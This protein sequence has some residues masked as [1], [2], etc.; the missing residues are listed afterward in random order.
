MRTFISANWPIFAIVALLA[1][2]QPVAQ[3][4]GYV[5]VETEL[6]QIETGVSDKAAVRRAIGMPATRNEHYGDAWFYV[7]SRMEQ[8]T[9]RAP[10]E[11]DRQVVVVS[12]DQQ[13]LVS[14]VERYTLEDGRAVALSSRVTETDFGRLTIIQQLLRSLGRIDPTQAFGGN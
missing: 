2:C 1:A 8:R 5:P 11:V 12:F 7:S 9:Y 4:F 13:G 10:Q 14:N 3:N 6:A